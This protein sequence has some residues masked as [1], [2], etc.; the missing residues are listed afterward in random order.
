MSRERVIHIRHLRRPLFPPTLYSFE[1]A[2][3]REKKLKCCFDK[4]TCKFVCNLGNR[5]IFI[6]ESA[7]REA[8]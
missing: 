8:M 2:D 1:G 5:L 3:A 6:N 4:E 7:I